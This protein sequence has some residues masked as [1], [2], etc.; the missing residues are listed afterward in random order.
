ME[1]KLKFSN[2]N[3]YVCIRV[4]SFAFSIDVSFKFDMTAQVNVKFHRH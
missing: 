3:S 1:I 2:Y 4:L